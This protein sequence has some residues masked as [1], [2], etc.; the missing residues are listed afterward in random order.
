MYT[1]DIDL[2]K[3]VRGLSIFLGI[4]ITADVI[5][6]NYKPFEKVYESVLG[7]L[8]REAEKVSRILDERE[9]NKRGRDWEVDH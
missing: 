5:R 1:N 7:I 4:V 2:H 3:I 6:L 9:E 8:M